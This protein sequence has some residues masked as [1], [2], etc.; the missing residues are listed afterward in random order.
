MV[1]GT[2]ISNSRI[3]PLEHLHSWL[4]GAFSNVWTYPHAFT[5]QVEILGEFTHQHMAPDGAFKGHL[6][7]G[8]GEPIT[9]PRCAQ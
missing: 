2:I 7:L 9:T 3:Y 6:S 8:A 1:A 4:C 5:E